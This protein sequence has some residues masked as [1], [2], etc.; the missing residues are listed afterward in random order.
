VSA[1]YCDNH[2]HLTSYD[3]E[4]PQAYKLYDPAIKPQPS[5]HRT[6]RHLM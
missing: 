4:Q 2:R 1:H 3:S 5:N 6:F